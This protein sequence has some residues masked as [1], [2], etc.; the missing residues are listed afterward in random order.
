MADHSLRK[1]V[2]GESRRMRKRSL[3]YGQEAQHHRALQMRAVNQGLGGVKEAAVYGC[4]PFFVEAYTDSTRRLAAA[5]A[6]QQSTVQLIAPVLEVA[7][8]AGI[9]LVGALLMTGGEASLS[10]MSTLA[11]FAYAL[12]RL[13][14][15][16]GNLVSGLH[17]LRYEHSAVGPVHDDLRRLES[18]DPAGGPAAREPS[19]LVFH[20]AI[21]LRHV[22][23]RYASAGQP[24]LVDINMRIPRG[25]SV[26][27]VGATGAGKSTLVDLIL[28]LLPPESGQVLVDGCD[29]RQHRGAWQRC[30]GYIPQVPY[31]LDETL[32]R[33]IAFGLPDDLIDEARVLEAA[34]MAQL[35]DLLVGLP[36]GMDTII[37]DRG[38]RLS[39]GQRQR[40]CIAR[41]L[42]RDP[43]VLVLDEATSA[44]DNATEQRVVDAL[45]AQRGSRTLIVVAHRL[46]TVRRCGLVYLLKAG[47]VEV[48][49][50]GEQVFR[51]A[52][53]LV[54][55]ATG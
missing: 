12:L 39:G 43:D 38:I 55:A 49:G 23:F 26:A 29:I 36:C 10:I 46:S 2:S 30:I 1:S 14:Q 9:A 51:H 35:D 42:Y 32:R 6:H 13:K 24:V 47:Q 33:N 18:P 22:T 8:V 15:T 44:L 20:D 54:R 19:R 37:G 5:A 17:R 40:V 50:T 16:G 45:E 7:S 34:R 3:A 25:A 28:G 52:D 41:A 31:L 53:P 4:E 11:L 27:I 21:E 48:A